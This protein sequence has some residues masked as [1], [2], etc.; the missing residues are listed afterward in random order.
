MPLHR[1]RNFDMEFVEKGG[2]KLTV[3]GIGALL[4]RKS[5]G[6]E[7]RFSLF[8]Q[9]DPSLYNRWSAVRLRWL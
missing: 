4:G 6:S 2:E 8:I 7:T 5:P 1:S 9:G 3:R